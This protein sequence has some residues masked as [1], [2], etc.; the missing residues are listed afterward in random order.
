MCICSFSEIVT[1]IVSY[2]DSHIWMKRTGLPGWL[3]GSVKEEEE[4]TSMISS[5]LLKQLVLKLGFLN[6][7]RNTLR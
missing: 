6:N 7:I 3:D 5:S 4:S 2:L 1:G